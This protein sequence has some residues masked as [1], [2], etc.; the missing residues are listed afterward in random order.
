MFLYCL[1]SIPLIFLLIDKLISKR[2]TKYYQVALAIFPL[3]LL[4]ALK[5][6]SV[7][8][9]TESYNRIFNT[10]GKGWDKFNETYVRIEVGY[11]ALLWLLTKITSWVQ[12]QYFVFATFT[13]VV[14]TRFFYKNSDNPYLCG[15]LF[16]GFN[17]YSFYMSGLRQ[18]YAMTIC[19]IA[20]EMIKKRKLIYFLIITAIAFLFHKA[21]LFFL[22]AYF[23]A[24]HKP[25]K[26]LA[27]LY[28][29]VIVV[30]AVFNKQ[31]F[32]LGAEILELNYGI[33]ETGNGFVMF[34][35]MAIIT[36][37]S[38]LARENLLRH[39]SNNSRLFMLNLVAML[40]WVLRLFSRT[41][42]RP[43]MFYAFFTILL[44]DQLISS[45][46]SVVR[47]RG[48]LVLEVAV[49]TLGFMY[50]VYRLISNMSLVPYVFF[51]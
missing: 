16:L 8:A 2:N 40:L 49:P 14:I 20:Y 31:I 7:G 13:F 38:F 43:S 27:F 48:I 24:N 47:D 42:E 35:I 34:S 1:S 6:E 21:A 46:K 3:F 33:E 50:F 17:L 32:G 30:V 45:Y 26:S 36:L 39:D 22:P 4:L 25:K 9:D 41:A 44:I 51:W 37:W 11:K 18:A 28:I 23:I 10:M 5:G 12:I 15:I 19:L 29:L